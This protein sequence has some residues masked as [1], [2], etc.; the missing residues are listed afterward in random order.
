MKILVVLICFIVEYLICV[1]C[2]GGTH[3]NSSINVTSVVNSY[4]CT[5]TNWSYSWFKAGAAWYTETRCK[6]SWQQ[7]MM[8]CAKIEPGRSTIA[9]IRSEFERKRIEQSSLLGDKRWTGGIRIAQN[10]WYWYKYNGKPAVILPIKKFFWG[11][12]EPSASSA[13]QVCIKLME[14]KRQ[15][16]DELCHSVGTALCELRCG[17]D[18]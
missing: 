16:T 9:T 8:Q 17:G 15:W 1:Y 5:P 3:G 13:S 2:D 18:E 11:K 14:N 10:L 4:K 12:D 6:G 7:M